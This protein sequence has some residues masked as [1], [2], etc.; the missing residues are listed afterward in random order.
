MIPDRHFSQTSNPVM[1][2]QNQ[3]WSATFALHKNFTIRLLQ[4]ALLCYNLSEKNGLYKTLVANNGVKYDPALSRLLQQTGFFFCAEYLQRLYHNLDEN[5]NLKKKLLHVLIRG[6]AYHPCPIGIALGICTCQGYPA[7]SLRS[8]LT[9]HLRR[10]VSVI[11]GRWC[12]ISSDTICS[13]LS[14]L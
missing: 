1:E 9:L 6:K 8:S 14:K 2:A 3:K 7:G 4:T 10:Y 5:K 13:A 12:P 11:S